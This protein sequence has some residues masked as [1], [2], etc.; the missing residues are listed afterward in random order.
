MEDLGCSAITN[1]VSAM[2]ITSIV[3]VELIAA[4]NQIQELGYMSCSVTTDGFISN[5][6]EDILKS[7]D[8]Y[9]LRRFMEASRLFL[10]DGADS[11]LWEIK[12]VQD[13]L[14]NFTTRGNVSLHDKAKNPMLWKDKEYPGVCAHNSTKSGFESDS[15]EDRHWLMTQVLSRTS[16][17]N[18]TEQQWTSFKEYVQ[19]KEYGIKPV[20]RH[21]RMDFDLKRKPIRMSFK[22]DRV[23]I[24]GVAYEIVHFDTEPYEDIKEFR[25]YRKKKE[26]TVCLRTESDWDIFWQK[27][28][29]Q[30]SKAQIHVDMEWSILNSCIMGYRAGRWDI[31]ALNGKDVDEKCEWI[32]AHNTSKKKFKPSNWKNARRPERQANMLP[33][34]LIQ[35]K[36]NELINAEN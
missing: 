4:Q 24:D 11:E 23:V 33:I 27:L 13:D 10:T 8:L 2:M 12:H 9:G 7:L 21:I 1:P 28:S 15:Y 29:L 20:T 17:V 36:L 34:E 30:N 6:P 25:L 3:Q 5:C 32:N 16:T 14:L 31:P 26:L 19:G 35:D 18:Y 22:T